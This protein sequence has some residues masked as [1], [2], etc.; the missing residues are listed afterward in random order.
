VI[1]DDATAQCWGA[2]QYGQ[3]GQNSYGFGSEPW[4]KYGARGAVQEDGFGAEI[5]NVTAIDLGDEH[6]CAIADDKVYCWGRNNLKQLGNI[7]GGSSNAA[8]EINIP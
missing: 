1:L 7:S 3:L 4:L 2:N 8:I 5:R 6:S